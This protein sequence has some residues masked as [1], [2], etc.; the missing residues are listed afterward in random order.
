MRK[1]LLIIILIVLAILCFSLMISGFKIG[2]FKINSYSDIQ[3]L[4]AQRN[5]LLSELDQ[6]NSVEFKQKQSEI[7]EAVNNYKDKKAQY[8]TLVAEGKITE[9]AIYSSMDIYNIDFLWTTIGNYATEKGVTLQFDVTKSSTVTSISSDYVMCDLNF[10]ITGEY[11]AITDF[12]YSLEDD[13]QLNFEIS[14][15]LIE[16]GGENLQATFIVKG[17]LINS[18]NLSSVPTSASTVYNEALNSEY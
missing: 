6:K 5:I 12:I 1:Y 17:V 14:D 16:K 8:D 13:D 7:S 18:Q 4:N 3:E 15:F 11:I 10:I 2:I 9:S